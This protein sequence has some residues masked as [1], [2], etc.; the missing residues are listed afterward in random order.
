M[1]CAEVYWSRFITLCGELK[2]EFVFSIRISNKVLIEPTSVVKTIQNCLKL[3]TIYILNKK[4]E[5]KKA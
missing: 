3:K 5:V 4:H 1:Q 2:S